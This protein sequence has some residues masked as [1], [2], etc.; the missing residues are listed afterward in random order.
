MQVGVSEKLR[1]APY[2]SRVAGTSRVGFFKL[3]TVDVGTFA[4]WGLSWAQEGNE[5]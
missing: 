4:T 5:Q 3:S 2:R 1:H